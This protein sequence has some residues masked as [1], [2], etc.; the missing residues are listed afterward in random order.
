VPALRIEWEEVHKKY[1]AT[2]DTAK[3]IPKRREIKSFSFLYQGN[4]KWDVIA[5][6][7]IFN[8]SPE[9]KP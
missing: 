9:V 7:G 1:T 4:G 6:S 2:V 3:Y 8:D 5:R